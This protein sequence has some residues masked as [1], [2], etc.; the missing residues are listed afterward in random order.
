MIQPTVIR[1]VAEADQR[2]QLTQRER[3]ALALLA[4]TEGLSAAALAERLELHDPSAS[5]PWIGRLLERGLV[6]QAGRARATRYVVPPELLREAGLDRLTNL[7]RVQPHRL[8]ALILEDLDR[9]P[10]LPIAEIHRRIGPEIPRR[11]LARALK[12]LVA[13]GRLRMEGV[14][15]WTRYRPDTP[16]DRDRRRGE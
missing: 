5:R 14:R 7:A 3:I 10:D 6:E 9:F 11:A 12:E 8:R 1:L 13:E 2:Y 16:I 4:Q 15:K